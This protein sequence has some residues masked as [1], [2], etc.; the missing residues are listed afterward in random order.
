M[1]TLSDLFQINGKPML[2]PD[3]GVEMSFEDLDASDSG[4]DEAG[5][6]HRIVVRHK[7][8]VW[9]FTYSH[10]TQAEYAYMLSILPKAGSFTFT[11]PALSDSTQ[12][13]ETTAY[14]SQYGIAWQSARTGDYRNLKFNIIEC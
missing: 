8:G 1:N 2:A 6:M 10:L 11:H 3:A 7:V 12:P 13:E 5:Y 14:L 9:S 4:R